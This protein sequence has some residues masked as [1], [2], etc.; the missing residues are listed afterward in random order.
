MIHYGIAANLA[1]SAVATAI[2]IAVPA[3]QLEGLIVRSLRNNESVC[4]CLQSR[5]QAPHGLPEREQARTGNRGD[6]GNPAEVRNK[7]RK[8]DK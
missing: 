2:L 3:C 1:F 4:T 7:R 6:L 8:R 5:G